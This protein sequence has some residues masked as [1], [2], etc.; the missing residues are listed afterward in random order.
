MKNILSNNF[1]KEYIVRATSSSSFPNPPSE[2]SEIL[3]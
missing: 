3:D 1:N 2:E